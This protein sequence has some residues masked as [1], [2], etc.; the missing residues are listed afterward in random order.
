VP[1][2]RLLIVDD[3]PYYRLR[4]SKLFARSAMTVVG[5]ADDGDVAIKEITRLEPDVVT[6]DLLMPRLDGFSVLRW[7]MEKHPV[8]I[9]VCSSF[10]DRD[11]ILRA[12]ELGAV[13]FVLKPAPNT[14]GKLLADE[15]RIIA[16]VEEAARATLHRRPQDTAERAATRLMAEQ[17]AYPVNI[18]VIC[19]AASTGGPA[20]IQHIIRSLPPTMS[21]PIVINQ[22]MPA[23]FTSPFAAR[24]NGL[25]HYRVLEAIGDQPIQQRNVYIAPAGLETRIVRAGTRLMLSVQAPARESV[26]TPSADV[27][28]GSIAESCG[29]AALAIILS[30][31]GDD[32]TAGAKLVKAVGGHVLAESSES[33]LVFGMPRSVI[34]AGQADAVLA[35]WDVPPVVAAYSLKR[36]LTNREG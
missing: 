23:G 17:Q 35:L 29:E 13:D 14:T 32:G 16:R 21:T 27:L 9:V 24:L 12:L 31:M 1:V 19:I 26:Q 33:A 22:H 7:A 4:L 25:S 20:A 6:L 15:E 5:L 3:S 30:G 36:S 10:A 28:L 2:A 18:E 34:E 8:P 11:R